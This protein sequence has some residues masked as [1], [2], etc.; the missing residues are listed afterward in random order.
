MT[1]KCF[2]LCSL[3]ISSAVYF[4]HRQTLGTV[5]FSRLP[6][7]EGHS[8]VI[9]LERAFWLYYHKDA[10][11]VDVRGEPEYSKGHIPGAIHYMETEQNRVDT[12]RA[13][14]SE[15]RLIIFYCGGQTCLS[16]LG[17]K[18]RFAA[19]GVTNTMALSGGF[20]EWIGNKLPAEPASPSLE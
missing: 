9:N 10:L 16:S 19:L 18:F 20:T 15:K 5:G 4:H 17:A 8:E 6:I 2:L 13:L 14:K 1:C 7:K 12:A 11:F 3:F